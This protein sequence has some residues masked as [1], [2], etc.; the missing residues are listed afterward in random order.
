MQS[1]KEILLS[2]ERG[3]EGETKKRHTPMSGD[4][5]L[6]A[7][8]IQK[9]IRRG[10]ERRATGAAISLWRQDRARFWRRLHI[11]ALEDVGIG[12]PDPVVK[13]LTAFS[14]PTWRKETGDMQVG[15]HLV[16]LLCAAAKNRLADAAFILAERAAEHQHLRER[17]AKA[18]EVTLAEYVADEETPLV[19]RCIA[20]WLLAGTKK[21]PSEHLPQRIGKPAE[22][23]TAMMALN[24]PASFKEACAGVTGASQWPLA[25]FLPLIWQEAQ[26]HPMRVVND[27]I[28]A[29]PEVEGVPLYACDMF[30]RVGLA[31]LRELRQEVRGLQAYSVKAI[32]LA[33]FYME[34]HRVNQRVTNDALEELQQRGELTDMESAGVW[35]PEYMALRE[36]LTE[37]MP[38][39]NDIRRRRLQRHL[40]GAA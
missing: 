21:F 1:S 28:P 18:D 30:T 31:S 23:I 2:I 34:G 29:T 19:E 32:G 9:A 11:I 6:L 10:E 16:R 39:L 22:A 17:L 26:K 12:A 40:E 8:A 36:L 27:A 35:L 25:L 13:T 33:L 15:L 4:A 20:V 38:L 37:N 14:S 5:W 24:L 7:S 3:I